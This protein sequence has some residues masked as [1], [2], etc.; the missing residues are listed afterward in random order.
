MWT[1]PHMA[2]KKVVYHA[3]TLASL[4]ITASICWKMKTA[5]TLRSST[6]KGWLERLQRHCTTMTKSNLAACYCALKQH[7]HK[8]GALQATISQQAWY[9]TFFD[10]FDSMYL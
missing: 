1:L 8:S 2:V 5:Q 4:S 6:G 9:H 3:C 10:T 7:N